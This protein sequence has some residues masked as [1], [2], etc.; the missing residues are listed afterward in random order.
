MGEN[1]AYIRVSTI[2]QNEE[3]QVEGLKKYDIDKTYKEKV[4]AKDTNRPQLKAMLEWARAGDTIYIHSFDR[5]ARDTRNLLDIVEELEKK[6]V[7]LISVK[8]NLDTSTPTGKLMLTLIAG[9]NE[10]ERAN[11]L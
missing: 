10:F 8:E 4:S 3:R 5:L 9:I 7:N 11:L 6:E 2:E 1:I